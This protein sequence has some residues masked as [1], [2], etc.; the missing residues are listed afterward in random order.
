MPPVSPGWPPCCGRRW[1]WTRWRW[2]YRRRP[3]TP[4]CGTPWA[5]TPGASPTCRW[6]DSAFWAAAQEFDVSRTLMEASPDAISEING[7]RVNQW[8]TQVDIAAPF[9]VIPNLGEGNLTDRMRGRVI[10]QDEELI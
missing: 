3:T 4:A 8:S 1:R 9:E 6:A 7:A 2:M 5:W 10:D